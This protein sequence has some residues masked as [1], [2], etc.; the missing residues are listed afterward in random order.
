MA[1]AAAIVLE[2]PGTVGRTL[3]FVDGDTPIEAFVGAR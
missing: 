2:T 3:D 1:A